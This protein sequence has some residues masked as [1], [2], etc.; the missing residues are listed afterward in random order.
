MQGKFLHRKLFTAGNFARL[1]SEL[2]YVPMMTA[3]EESSSR[4]YAFGQWQL[5]QNRLSDGQNRGVQL[6]PKECAVLRLLLAARGNIVTKEQLLDGVWHDGE[7]AEESLTRCIYSLRKLLAQDKGLIASVYGRG[8]R[9]TVPVVMLSSPAQ[10]HVSTL[11]VLPFRGVDPGL[12]MELHEQIIRRLTRLFAPGLRLLPASLTTGLGDENA[13]LGVIQRLAPDYLLVGR[14]AYVDGSLHV[15]VE[16]IRSCDHALMHSEASPV[17]SNDEAI[18]WLAVLIAQ[19][20]PG[21]RSQAQSCATYPLALAYLNGL[22]AFHEFTPISLARAQRHFRQCIRLSGAYAPTWSALADTWLGQAALG[23]VPLIEAVAQAQLAVDEALK[24]DPDSEGGLVRLALLTSLQGGVKAA[25]A[26]FRW[27]R[28]NA[29]PADFWYYHAWHEW[30]CGD[31][32]AAMNSIDACLRHDAESIPASMLR[33]RIIATLNPDA[34]LAIARETGPLRGHPLLLASVGEQD[35]PQSAPLF[36]LPDI[37]SAIVRP[38]PVLLSLPRLRDP[39][40]RG[41]RAGAED[42]YS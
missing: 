27:A 5:K 38:K 37:R 17:G 18:Q 25:Q 8:Y 22:T 6:P 34:A 9:F 13:P 23:Q 12:R 2:E 14:C 1:P 35:N 26:L 39:G 29:D 42:C 20:V 4:S 15:S 10:A 11:A 3:D 28:P 31:C 30:A 33:L 32:A 41:F 19:R 40:S 24:L 7:V 36:D 16:L 21:I